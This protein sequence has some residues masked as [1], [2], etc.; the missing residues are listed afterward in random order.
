[1]VVSSRKLLRYQEIFDLFP[2]AIRQ[3]LYDTATYKS[4]KRNEYAMSRGEVGTF[5]AGVMSGR[6]R[7]CVRSFEGKEMLFSMVHPGELFGE[8]SVLDG[9]P[10]AVDVIADTDCTLIVIQ[11]D[12]F[13]N[14]MRSYPESMLG[15]L[16]LTCHRMRHYV[17][18]MGL[19]ALEDLPHR[20]AHYLLRLAED[21][22]VEQD[23]QVVIANALSQT[24]IGQQLACSR[25]SV[26]KQLSTFVKQGYL[27][28]E[29]DHIVLCNLEAL[30]QMT[31]QQMV[32]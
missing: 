10:R 15:M 22:G 24:D 20:M 27:V 17:H 32:Q 26:N 16:R 11:K 29:K 2:P 31:A 12:E 5:M 21:F 3:R 18:T 7:M 19:I 8:M 9:G 23:G 25:E 30:K 14:L 6:M 4:L 28:I 1:M 13:I